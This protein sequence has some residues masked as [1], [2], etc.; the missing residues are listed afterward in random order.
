M[1]SVSCLITQTFKRFIERKRP[2]MVQPPRAL[3]ISTQR[4]SSL[5][6]RVVIAAPTII[7]ALLVC[8]NNGELS[9]TLLLVTIGVFVLASVARVY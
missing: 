3:T 5:P 4:S 7:Y 1:L 6:S 8:K 9:I 2:S